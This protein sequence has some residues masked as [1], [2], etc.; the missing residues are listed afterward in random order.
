MMREMMVTLKNSH[1]QQGPVEEDEKKLE[2]L[3]SL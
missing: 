1:S 3:E 2:T